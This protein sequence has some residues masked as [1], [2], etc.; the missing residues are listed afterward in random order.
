MR[1][2]KEALF[3]DRFLSKLMSIGKSAPRKKF[4]PY[5]IVDQIEG[6]M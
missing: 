1:F 3:M 6:E 2:S 5:F 4:E